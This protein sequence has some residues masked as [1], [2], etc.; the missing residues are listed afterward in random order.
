MRERRKKKLHYERQAKEQAEDGDQQTEN[1]DGDNDLA[2]DKSPENVATTRKRPHSDSSHSTEQK[3]ATASG[4]VIVPSRLSSREAKKFRKD[5]RR[6]A[7]AQGQDD[8]KLVFMSEDEAMQQLAVKK[9]NQQNHIFPNLNELAKEQK[10]KQKQRQQDVAREK[11]EHELPDEI[12]QRYVALDCEMVGIGSSGKQSALARASLT[13]WNGKVLLDSYVQVPIRVT[14]FRT[15]FSG[16]VPKHISSHK[17]L[18]LEE[19][20]KQVTELLHD[21]I[22]VGHAL[23]NDLQALMLS[24]PPDDIRDTSRYRPYQRLGGDGKYRPR[25]LRDLA[26]E[27]CDITIQREGQSHD[28]VDDA[29]ATMELFKVSRVAWEAALER[30]QRYGQSFLKQS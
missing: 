24:H 19:C 16:V 21:K 8:S 4:V 20:R 11:A 17:A 29:R 12:K 23:K 27:H 2:N 22:L 18:T 30:K 7:R 3:D 1:Q 13:D 26:A 9:R 14:D 15:K 28:S 25:K 6:S 5:T 10:D